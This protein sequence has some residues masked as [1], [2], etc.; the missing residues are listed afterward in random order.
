MPITR[1]SPRCLISTDT[2]SAYNYSAIWRCQVCRVLVPP[3]QF[4]RQIT[5][6]YLLPYLGPQRPLNK[7]TSEHILDM[8]NSMRRTGYAAQTIDHV[9]TV[10]KIIFEYARKWRKITFNPFDAVDPPEVR[11][12]A[13]MPLT[14][15]EAVAL[16]AAVAGHRLYALYVLTLTLG[17][18][19]GELLGL[20]ING[21][22]LD[23]ASIAITQQ[24]LDLD[25]SPS[26]KPYTKSGYSTRILPLAAYLVLLLRVRLAQIQAE[27]EQDGWVEHG[28]L[29][30]S[31]RGTPM[32]QRNLNRHFKRA[33]VTA[34]LRRAVR[35][36]DAGDV[37]RS[38]SALRF[39]HLRHT[40][41]S[42]L[43]DT[44]ASKNIIQAV[45]GHAAADVTDRYVH[46]SLAALREAIER[47]AQAKLLMDPQ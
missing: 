20:T 29:F 22:D 45:A 6:H 47:M 15:A 3:E 16:L 12:V 39:H 21:I 24:V 17:L 10:G 1:Q 34:Q 28:L 27:R 18:R 25:G 7:I 2:A 13:P 46:V 19:K 43:G 36:D 11:V 44:G 8:L 41:L 5:E 32:S 4:Y 40:C 33:C 42:W 9:Y 14:E 38:G 37:E 35:T 26:I 30:S 31:E 23:T